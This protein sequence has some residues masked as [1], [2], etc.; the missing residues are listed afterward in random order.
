MSLPAS[1]FFPK[2]KLFREMSYAH[3]CPVELI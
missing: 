3:I 2:R 1:V